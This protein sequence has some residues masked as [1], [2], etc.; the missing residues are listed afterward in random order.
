MS[1]FTGKVAL[2]TGA[3][4]GI[5]AATAILFSKLGASVAITGR[6][7]ANLK[8]VSEKCAE[9]HRASETPL[10]IVGD[11]GKENDVENLLKST[12]ERYGKLDILV[13]NAG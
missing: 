12:I 10:V 9:V 7:S 6:N 13:N 8:S 5:G 11:V 1:S 3:S 4:S 2:I